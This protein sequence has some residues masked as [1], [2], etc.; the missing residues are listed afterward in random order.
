MI[1]V[2]IFLIVFALINCLFNFFSKKRENNNLTHS[3]FL[4]ESIFVG[5]VAYK[6]SDWVKNVVHILSNS[7]YPSRVFIGVIEYVMDLDESNAEMVPSKFRNNVRSLSVTIPVKETWKNARMKIMRSLFR[8]EKY[9]LFI[10]SAELCNGWDES[11]CDQMKKVG[12][13]SVLVSHLRPFNT[14]ACIIAANRDELSFSYKLKQFRFVRSHV[15]IPSLMWYPDFSFCTS[16]V[17]NI[18]NGDDTILGVS[19]LLHHN[20]IRIFYTEFA[21]GMRTLHPHGVR[22]GSK[23]LVDNDIIGKYFDYLGIK[24]GTI[25]KTTFNGITPD[26][27]HNEYIHKYGS[28]REARFMLEKKTMYD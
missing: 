15:P 3:A 5:I 8:N 19:A 26:C 28:V 1:P 24:N 18:I 2:H 4:T 12:E 20:G 27:D 21:I 25:E 11:L 7:R 10:K 16:E 14:F 22:V 9:T 6:D 17:A 13:K 23:C